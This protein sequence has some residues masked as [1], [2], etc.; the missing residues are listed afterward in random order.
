[1]DDDSAWRSRPPDREL[2]ALVDGAVHLPTHR[3]RARVAAGGPGVGSRIW[4]RPPF[5]RAWPS[6]RP[7]CARTRTRDRV[8]SVTPDVTRTAVE[9]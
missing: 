9:L 6:L 8:A 2:S 7:T 4:P 1:M 5:L 3:V